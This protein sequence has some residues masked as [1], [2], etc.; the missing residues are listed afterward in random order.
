[1]VRIY[2][3]ALSQ[4]EI[5]T[6][7]NTALDETSQLP[8]PTS[9]VTS[10]PAAEEPTS[11]PAA[12]PTDAPTNTPTPTPTDQ[13]TP[14]PG[15][16]P[17]SGDGNDWSQ[18]GHDAQK[19][20]ASPQSV[21]G[22]YR[23]YWRW[24]DVPFASRVQP[25]VADGRLFVGGLNGTFYA[26]DAAY[27]AEGGTPRVL[28]Q[29]DLGSPVRSG[30]AVD[31]STVVVGT[32]HGTIYGLD[33][34]NGQ[35]L[36]SVSTGGAILAAPLVADS[37]AYLG[38]ADG[39]F[40]ALRTSD[41]SVVWKQSIGV[42]I[43]G[44]AAMSSDGSK[45]FF[46]AENV[47]AYALA[48]TSGAVVWQTQLQGQSG[49][50]RWPV[51]LGNLVVF[52]TQPIGYFHDL[53]HGGDDVM[54]SAGTR[55]SDWA[56]DWSIVKPKIVLQLSADP[57]E[58]TFFALDTTTGQSKGTAPVLYT[59]GT[60]DAPSPP[61]VYNQSLYLP[62]RARHGIQTDSSSAN[63]VT[64]RY[65]AELGRMD[66]TSLDITGLTTP[67]SFSYQ[68]RLTSDEAGV[69]TVAGNMLLSDSWERLGGIRLT[70]GRLVGM[71]QVAH[72][73]SYWANLAANNDLMPFYDNG[74]FQGPQVGEG[75]ARAGAVVG[76]G[77][78]FWHVQASGLA[79]IG[80]SDGSNITSELPTATVEQSPGPLPVPTQVTTQALKDIIWTEPQQPSTVPAD[81]T[82]KL[83]QEVGRIVAT[84]NHLMPFYLERGFHGAGSWPPDV[85]N[86][87]EPAKV[88]DSKVYW[89]DPGELV[90]T[91]S[92]A[93]PYLNTTMQ[94]QLKSYL[95]SEMN[96]FP[97][98][99]NLP[100]PTDSWL[101][102]GQPRELYGVPMRNSVNSWPPPGVP[103]QT[104]YAMWAYGR[105]TGD[106]GYVGSHWPEI[107][108]LFNA[109]RNSIS[110][111]AEIAGAIGYARIAKQ[112]NYSADATDGET[113]A[114][115]AMQS[116]LNFA[117]WL[118]NANALYP[119]DVNRPY[120]KP[121]RR[122]AVLFGL[123][124]EIGRY[125]Q[126][127]NR[128][129]VEYT[130]NDV[131]GYPDGSFLWYATRLGLQA[132]TGESSYHS[133][134]LAWAVFLAQAYVRQ[135]GQTQL[136]YWLDRPWGLGDLWYI[137]KL[138]ATVQ[139]P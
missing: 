100:W 97:P 35:V 118:N 84:N 7:M 32:Q 8:T 111:Y 133:P 55:L 127:T 70:D 119:P 107:K 6:D 40:Y 117:Q 105:Y 85:T 68:F 21:D 20:N 28:W 56:A 128:A 139:A 137:Q 72:D 124:P 47:K 9:A 93:Y 33:V 101:K 116:G 13:V 75:N 39:N 131:A 18:L 94:S 126:I 52:R 19:S 4:T 92:M 82:Q 46:V 63:H 62:F 23:F 123:T 76:S 49:S 17:T 79:A 80:P 103:I 138:V 41:G 36:W 25:V 110:S 121:G 38:S 122:A 71:A 135:S 114:V 78:I 42:P 45:L 102:Q 54:D 29:R 120:E 30:A 134:E 31:G 65:D 104:I 12:D 53:L 99:Q 108:N 132:E 64:S 57:S 15:G 91:L 51:V 61:T 58:Q 2:D 66:P 86:D 125:L 130:I 34:S 90:M 74:P 24:T 77:R 129:A 73:S 87:T 26:L 136:R 69:M 3:R 95:Q 1:E 22:P 59:F 106:W 37:T 48:S 60:N 67:D 81:L 89:F 109:K 83:E 16:V 50:D 11:T 88:G 96:R 14:T 43:L 113:V 115:S 44:S 98:L 27:D 10:T 112:L 5:Q